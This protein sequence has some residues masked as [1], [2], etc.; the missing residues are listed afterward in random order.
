MYCLFFLKKGAGCVGVPGLKNHLNKPFALC[1]IQEGF[2]DLI[3]SKP[4]MFFASTEL[5]NC[6]Y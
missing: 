4:V 5:P 2:T 3:F 6:S 1:C